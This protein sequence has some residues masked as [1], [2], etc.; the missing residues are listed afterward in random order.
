M[1]SQRLR[2]LSIPTE[3]FPHK[4]HSVAPGRRGEPS[5]VRGKVEDPFCVWA[6]FELSE[7]APE[8]HGPQRF[9]LLHLRADGVSAFRELYS[10]IENPEGQLAEFVEDGPADPPVVLL[11]GGLGSIDFYREPCWP[12]YEKHV[13]T[14]SMHDENRHVSVWRRRSRQDMWVVVPTVRRNV[15]LAGPSGPSFPHWIP[16]IRTSASIR[17]T[18]MSFFDYVPSSALSRAR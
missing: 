3:L 10:A 8:H 12:P 4:R 13:C 18:H 6:V 16:S 7:D 15:H 1:L 17:L 9:S 5:R 14:I 2:V 11:Y